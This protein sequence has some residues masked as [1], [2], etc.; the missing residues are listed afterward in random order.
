MNTSFNVRGEPIVCTPYDAYRCFMS[1]EM[2]AMVL[3]NFLLLKEEQG[4]WPEEKGHIEE[5]NTIPP[6]DLDNPL[7]KALRKIFN[8]DFL[9]AAKRLQDQE[10]GIMI[11]VFR[12]APTMWVDHSAPSQSITEIPPELDMP[13][14]DARRIAE[15]MTRFWRYGNG[16]DILR[17]IVEK[18][19][20][21]GE[22][23]LNIEEAPEQVH[24]SIYVMY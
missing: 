23:F 22:Q 12:R 19:L 9:P 8:R 4:S 17:A 16:N 2:D 10:G 3:G 14:S 15:A 18:L 7:I 24:D 13:T 21:V 6:V 20:E 11:P 5:D 1:T